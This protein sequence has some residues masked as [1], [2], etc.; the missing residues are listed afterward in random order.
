MLARGNMHTHASQCGYNLP[1]GE[2]TTRIKRH[3]FKLGDLAIWRFKMVV[4]CATRDS[5]RSPQN[6]GKGFVSPC[7]ICVPIVPNER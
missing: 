6:V 2:N 5:F 1:R 7:Y 3:V 4:V